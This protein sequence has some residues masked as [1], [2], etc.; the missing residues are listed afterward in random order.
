MTQDR[1]AGCPEGA[2]CWRNPPRGIYCEGWEN[3]RETG[4]VWALLWRLP[5]AGSESP[6]HTGSCRSPGCDSPALSECSIARTFSDNQAQAGKQVQIL[7]WVPVVSCGLSSG[8][9]LVFSLPLLSFLSPSLVPP[10]AVVTLV[11]PTTPSTGMG[12]H[13]WLPIILFASM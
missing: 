10:S 8:L 6:A 13:Q 3:G 12:P 2:G 4:G 1:E 5:A 9:Q 11:C 7:C